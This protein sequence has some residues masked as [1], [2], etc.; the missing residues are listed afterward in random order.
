MPEIEAKLLLTDP[1]Q[2]AALAG[3][4]RVGPVTV[5]ERSHRS[6]VDTYYDTPGRHLHAAGGSI[7]VR[8]VG[9]EERFTVKEGR[10]EGGFATRMEIEEK[11]EGRDL[12]GWL[13]SLVDSGRLVLNVAPELLEPVLEIRTER[14]V[15]LLEG[16]AEVEMAVDCARYV[17]PGGEQEEWELELELLDGP[18]DVLREAVAALREQFELTPAAASKYQRGLDAVGG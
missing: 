9:N 17:G 3:L 8:R 16:P 5:R 15:V 13:L 6:Q 14:Q 4:E 2:A 12:P 1:S 11:A 7:R 18:E 10:V